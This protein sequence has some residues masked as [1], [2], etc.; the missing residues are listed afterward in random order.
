MYRTQWIPLLKLKK[1]FT[2][3]ILDSCQKKSLV[4]KFREKSEY[5]TIVIPDVVSDSTGY[6]SSCLKKFTAVKTTEMDGA[7]EMQKALD[8]QAKQAANQILQ[9]T[10]GIKQFIE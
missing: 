7:V 4:Y 9:E 10:A 6:H 8:E 2:Q 5:K 3:Q 1:K